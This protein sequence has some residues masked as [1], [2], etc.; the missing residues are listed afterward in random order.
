[1]HI[2]LFGG[3]FNP[4]HCGHLSLA[5]HLLATEPDVDEVWLVVSPMNPFKAHASDL[6]ADDLRLRLTRL[7]VEGEAGLRVSDC[8]MRLPRPSYMYLTL[9][10]LRATC[11]GHRFSLLIGADNWVAFRRWAEWQEILAAHEVLVYPRENCPVS[12]QTLPPGVRLIDAPLQPVSSTQIRQRVARG[13]PVSGLVPPQIERE[14]ER[15]YAPGK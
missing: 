14:V 13:L 5:R 2:L 4:V 6:L 15:L 12:A 8:E 11:P 3:S 7:A 9:R 10:H 1:M